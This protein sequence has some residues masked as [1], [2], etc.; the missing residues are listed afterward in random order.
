MKDLAIGIDIGATFTKI[1]ITDKE[2]N[3]L[4]ESSIST[5]KHDK[6]EPYLSELYEKISNDLKK[7][8]NTTNLIGIGVGAPNGNYHKGTIENPPNLRWK[9]I[10]PFTDLMKKYFNDLPVFLTNDANA[11][12][13]GENIFG[14]GKNMKNFVMITL[15]TGLGGGIIID[16][17][18]YYGHDGFAG[19]LGHINVKKNG[20]VCGC[21]KRGCLETYV[22][23]TGIRRTIYELLSQETTD[24]ELRNISFNQLT[25]KMITEAAE[26]GDKIAL[27]AFEITGAS[28]G[29]A[30]ADIVVILSPEAF[31][32]F[33]GLT[34]AGDFLL[35]PTRKHFENNLMPIFKNKIKILP[36][37]L[38]DKNIAILGASA[39][40]WSALAK[41]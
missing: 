15:G 31:F 32:L 24:S 35:K 22:S 29:K 17:K 19:E 10:I 41:Y 3:I 27:E 33:G 20:R 38:Q 9:G 13:M 23:A 14:A 5:D 40:V 6:I 39:M 7:I 26:K 36:S 1:G 21:G 30:L 25:A 2:G 4:T 34:N 18:L 8:E 12:A 28:L 11:A 16:D 37:G